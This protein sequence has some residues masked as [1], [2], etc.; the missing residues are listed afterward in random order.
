GRVAGDEA[1]QIFRQHAGIEIVGAAGLVADIAGHLLALVE[2]GDLVGS[3]RGAAEQGG[4]QDEAS[5]DADHFSSPQVSFQPAA[6]RRAAGRAICDTDTPAAPSR[7]R[8]T[9]PAYS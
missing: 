4:E 9:L 5:G 2:I 8:L 6:R 3:A 7:T 1:R